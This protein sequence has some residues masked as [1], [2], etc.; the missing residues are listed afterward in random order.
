MSYRIEYAPSVDKYEIIRAKPAMIRRFLFLG[1]TGLFCAMLLWPG[2]REVVRSFL[3]P[4]ED[5][6]TVLAFQT[7]TNDLRSGAGLYEAIYDF[8]RMVIHGL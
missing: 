2:G 8:C 4:G 7:M 5:A 6:V 3:I 1:A